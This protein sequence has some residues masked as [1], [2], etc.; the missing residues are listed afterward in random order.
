M[1][2]MIKIREKGSMISHYKMKRTLLL[3]IVSILISSFF[4]AS[5][6]I[7]SAD[8]TSYYVSNDGNDSNDGLSD[9]TP[10]PSR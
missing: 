3:I 6:E 8:S 2:S 10:L 1:G 5:V 9:S 4:S 7:V